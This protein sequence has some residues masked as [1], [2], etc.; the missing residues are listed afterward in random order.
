[1]IQLWQDPTIKQLLEKKG[2][3]L[4][5]TPGLWML[6]GFYTSQILMLLSSFLDDISRIT[7]SRYVPTD[8]ISLD[9]S[10]VT[11]AHVSC[12]RWYPPCAFKDIRRN[13]VSVFYSRRSEIFPV[14]NDGKHT[15]IWSRDV[16]IKYQGLDHLWCWWPK[17]SCVCFSC[18]CQNWLYWHVSRFSEVSGNNFRRVTGSHASPGCD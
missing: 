7:S 6:F 14:G 17:I 12:C 13:R 2:I 11:T 8:G 3:R 15:N 1:M 4:E 18:P 16:G 5:D 9:L 10:G